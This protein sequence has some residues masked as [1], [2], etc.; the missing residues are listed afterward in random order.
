MSWL[1]TAAVLGYAVTAPPALSGAVTQKGYRIAY[2]GQIDTDLKFSE[3]FA[4]EHTISAWVMPEFTYSDKAPIFGV[5]GTDSFAVG[6][7]DYR[8]GNGGYM[9][10]GDPVLWIKVNG[11]EAKYLAPGYRRRNWNHIAVTRARLFDGWVFLLYLN[12]QLLYPMGAHVSMLGNYSPSGTLRLGR[13]NSDLYGPQFYGHVDDVAVFDKAMSGAEIASLINNGIPL[14]NLVAAYTF[15]VV[16]GVLQPYKFRRPTT[17]NSR[18]F[19]V[20]LSQPR[21]NTVDSALFDSPLLVAPSSVARRLPFPVGQI[22]RVNQEFD[23][24]GG[25]HNGFAA[26]AVD[27]ERVDAP[28]TQ[29]AVIASSP[30]KVFYASDSGNGAVRVEV[31]PNEEYDV[32]MHT[33]VGSFTKLVF[34]PSGLLWWPNPGQPWTWIAIK[35]DQKLVKLD[36]GENHLH[37]ASTNDGPPNPAWPNGRTVPSAFLDYQVSKDQGATW[38]WVWR[39]MPRNG[40]WVRRVN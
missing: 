4:G 26:F 18:A 37:F 8:T 34:N 3:F 14:T 16:T 27:F 12:G 39:G 19:H 11:M 29:D 25:S 28:T 40:Q 20:V 1:L 9:K 15:N 24:R 21:N 13:T 22:W 23:S 33:A 30:A 2:L 31:V 35:Q 17:P 32:Y 36:P 6:Q 10:A 7:G 5:N 38:Q